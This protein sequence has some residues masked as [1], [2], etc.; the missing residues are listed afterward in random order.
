M[1]PRGSEQALGLGGGQHRLP[2]FWPHWY[3]NSQG[4][5]VEWT[6]KMPFDP[7]C[8]L[9]VL[10]HMPPFET[11]CVWKARKSIRGTQAF[12]CAYDN[13]WAVSFTFAVVLVFIIALWS[14]ICELQVC[15][16][17]FH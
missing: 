10:A 15:F 12:K 2:Y 16:H 17:S 3:F 1:A 13:V 9:R 6:E 11:W 14:G 4:A 8:H 7:N 5:F